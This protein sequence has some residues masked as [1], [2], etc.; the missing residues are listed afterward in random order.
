MSG[1][2]D[3][4]S[5]AAVAQQ[6]I[7]RQAGKPHLLACSYAFDQ[8][9]ECDE[10]YYSRT[11]AD[12]FGIDLSYV[13]AEEFWY[14]GDDEAFTPS[15]ETPVM[16]EES[17]TRDILGI[18]KMQDARV[19]LTGHGGDNL[20]A[21][22]SLVCS[23]RL[24][25]GDLR[26]IWEVTQYWKQ[27]ELPFSRLWWVYRDWFIRPL[28]PDF[29]RKFVRLFRKPPL[30]PD[31]LQ[32]DFAQRTHILERLST[33]GTPRRF[34]ERARQANY[35]SAVHI[36]S[37][38]MAIYWA[39]RLGAHFHLEAR[40]PFLDRR[41][42]EFLMSIPPEQTFKNG[43]QKF[44]LREAMRGILPEVVRTRLDKTEFSSYMG[45]GLRYK[46]TEKIRNLLQYPLHIGQN[47]VY[48]TKVKSIYENYVSE[49]SILDLNISWSFI[50]LELWLRKYHEIM[51]IR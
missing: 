14:L 7:N 42:A 44:I 48:L 11:M 24:R 28:I 9:Q 23:D 16:A 19:W 21:G 22:S 34:S 4:T 47:L 50:S 13:P 10:T 32:A 41:L 45:L 31:W 3:S 49:G 46:E 51:E 5:V 40:H 30:P 25:R 33:P 36:D 27:L 37:L 26:A 38:Q 12:E 39:E 1:V 6:I 20:V 18:F 2:M 17:L 8:L 29:I 15:L 35:E 43:L